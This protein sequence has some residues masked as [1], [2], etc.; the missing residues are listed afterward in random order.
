MWGVG[1]LLGFGVPRA[2]LPEYVQPCNVFPLVLLYT[3][4]VRQQPVSPY[5]EVCGANQSDYNPTLDV[6]ARPRVSL[7]PLGGQSTG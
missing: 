4:P 6:S 3:D 2:R 1:D 7:L 5:A